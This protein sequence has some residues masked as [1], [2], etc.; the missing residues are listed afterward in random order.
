MRTR[1]GFMKIR[2]ELTETE[3]LREHDLLCKETDMYGIYQIMDDGVSGNLKYMSME[4]LKRNGEYPKREGYLL[5]YTAEL[6]ETDTLDD[7][8]M[9][10]N[11]KHP[12]DFY[13]HSLSVSD[14]VVFRKQ[15]K[16][17]VFYVD[18]VGFKELSEF[19]GHFCIFV[20]SK[21]IEQFAFNEMRKAFTVYFALPKNQDNTLVFQSY[22]GIESPLLKCENGMDMLVENHT[23]CQKQTMP[24]VSYSIR[25]A[26]KYLLMNEPEEVAFKLPGQKGYFLIQTCS[27]GFDYT[28]CDADYKEVDG[29]QLDTADDPNADGEVCLMYQAVKELLGEIDSYSEN[30][31]VVDYLELS[32]KVE[33][34]NRIP[35]QSAQMEREWFRME[36]NQKF[37]PIQGKT[38]MEIEQAVLDYARSKVL[39]NGLDAEIVDAVVYGSRSRGME[40]HDSDVDVAVEYKGRHVREDFLFDLLHEDD[41]LIGDIPVDINPICENEAGDFEKYL[42]QAERCLVEKNA[43]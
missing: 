36:T 20:S 37:Q 43:L 42:Q 12:K 10:F 23:S 14:V 4:F 22:C 13:G 27:D 3:F 19:F 17:R 5:V 7:I 15:G 26:W 8:F 34:A 33:K 32:E 6:A 29:G 1:D 18:S 28:I 2:Q 31:E 39:E 21:M 25:E 35:F 9:R 11:M 41:F 40:N 24:E 30:L 16:C 38:A